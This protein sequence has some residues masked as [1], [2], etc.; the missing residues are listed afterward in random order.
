MLGKWLW[1][2]PLEVNSLWYCVI[3]TKHGLRK[4]GWDE[5]DVV[6]GSTRRPWVIILKGKTYFVSNFKLVVGNGQRVRF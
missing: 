5:V 6:R 1:R 2:F 4:N 3:K